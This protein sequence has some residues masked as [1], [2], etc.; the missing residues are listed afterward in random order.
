MNFL[1]PGTTMNSQHYTATL[2]TLKEYLRRFQKHKNILLQLDNARPHI[3]RTTMEAI[4]KLDL[5]ISPHPP[6][7]DAM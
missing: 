5:T 2:K 6:Y 7:S 1:E 4:E 3:S